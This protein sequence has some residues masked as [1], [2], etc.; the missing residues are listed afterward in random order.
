MYLKGS[1]LSLKNKRRRSNPWLIGFLI[2]TIGGL[3]YFNS[4]VVPDINPPF[5][6]TPTETRDPVSYEI[7]ADALAAEGKFIAA[8][9]SYQAA[10][11]A[12]P[13][14][15]ENYLKI[16]RLQIY[17]GSYEQAKVNAENAILLNKSSSTAY[18]LLGWAKGFQQL[19]LEGELDAKRGIEIDPNNALGHAV[20]AYLLALR[21]EAGL[22]ELDT[23]DIAIEE[24]RTAL[25][26][27]SNLLESRWA[28]GYVLEIT[29]NYADAAE[30][31]EFAIQI[32][33]YISQLH[34]ALGRNYM[35]LGRNDE[36]VFEFTKAY[37]LNP[38]DPVPNYFI[39]RV[40]GNL[41]EWAKGIQYGE[42]ALRD[43]PADPILYANLGTMY[44]RSGSYN[45]AI[46]YLDKAVRG[47]VTEEGVV[48]EGLPLSYSTSVIETY[49]RY[50]L[51]LARVN[52]C[53]DAVAVANAMLQ[54]IADDP[55]GVFN[56]EEII[57]ICQEN[58]VNPP[59]PTF[60][61]TATPITGPSPTPSPTNG[62][63]AT[64]TP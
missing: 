14:N 10:I 64:P 33:S 56:A 7:E 57:R 24:S 42:Q 11:N 60:A 27:D 58:L 32:N 22:N 48:V 8:I 13:Q 23:M 6:P 9:D 41:G 12:N 43:D 45:Q 18:A 59:T 20:Y 1:K 2:L 3:I 38:T 37:S 21:I 50:G 52:R 36:A 55:N 47:G 19:Y 40:Y 17:S 25:A 16:A 39:S 4:V 46:T 15:V 63:Q 28:R 54:T 44:Y 26:L 29:S 31:Y 34:I 30:Q 49:S 62:S 61:P 53:N 35:T 5:V 51:S